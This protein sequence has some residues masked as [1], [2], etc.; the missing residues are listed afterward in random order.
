MLR[1]TNPENRTYSVDVL[2]DDKLTLMQNKNV[3]DLVQFYT[4]KGGPTPYNLLINQVTVDGIGG[5]LWHQP[6]V[7]NLGGER[8]YIDVRLGKTKAPQR[9]GDVAL[10]L[11]SLDPKRNTYSV[12]V[13]ADDKLILKK[14]KSVNQPVQFY[15]IKGGHNPYELVINQVN[16]DGVVGYLSTPKGTVAAGGNGG[17][18][19]HSL[20]PPTG[21]P[22]VDVVPMTS[23]TPH[24]DG[25]GPRSGGPGSRD[26]D[27]IAYHN[28]SLSHLVMTAYNLKDYELSAP[29][30]LNEVGFQITATLPPGTTDTQ[31]KVML[32]NLLT[33]RFKLAVHPE[34]KVIPVYALVVAKDGP[35]FKESL[36]ETKESGGGTFSQDRRTHRLTRQT[37]DLLAFILSNEV[38]FPVRNMTGLNGKYDFTLSWVPEPWGPGVKVAHSAEQG[39][40][41]ISPTGGIQ[42]NDTRPDL[43]TAVQQQLGLRLEEL[44][45]TIQATVVD[46]IERIP[47]GNE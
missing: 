41:G 47:L 6:A 42:G 21:Q 16:K 15:T 23:M 22:V 8:N 20:T 46:H 28:I 44:K 27:H 19:T 4:I 7:A 36:P 18:V 14:D 33:Q 26:P 10:R 38:G 11:D 13:L 1:E 29:E 17:T 5:Y 43:F 2:A 45:G 3:N 39:L 25:K 30:W 35:K 24:W 12:E 9:F 31:V 34:P 40:V 37:T 32:Q